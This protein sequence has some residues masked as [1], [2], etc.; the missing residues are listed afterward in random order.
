[1]KQSRSEERTTPLVL[2]GQGRSGAEVRAS[3]VLV[4]WAAV[5]VLVLVACAALLGGLSDRNLSSPLGE[6]EMWWLV[7]SGAAPCRPV[8]ARGSVVVLRAEAGR[9]FFSWGHA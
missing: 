5:L 6:V 8:D 9:H 1:M 7:P 3:S 2:G 4:A